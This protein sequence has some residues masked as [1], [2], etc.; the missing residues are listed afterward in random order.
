MLLLRLTLGLRLWGSSNRAACLSGCLV[1]SRWMLDM[2]S[3]VNVFGVS[4]HRFFL[5][6]SWAVFTV[7]CHCRCQ[8]KMS[9]SDW[10]CP[11][12]HR[13]PLVWGGRPFAVLWFNLRLPGAPGCGLTLLLLHSFESFW[14]FP[15]LGGAGAPE[16]LELVFPFP[17]VSRALRE[18]Q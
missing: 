14:I 12:T 11:R 10:F 13:S 16:E 3:S 18:P 17:S 6:S 8:A 9:S 1:P 4:F 5:A 7:C 15:H 2:T